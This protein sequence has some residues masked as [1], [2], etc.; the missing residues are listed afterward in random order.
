MRL[1]LAGT[2]NSG[3]GT[4]LSQALSGQASTATAASAAANLGYI[5]TP[6]FNANRLIILDIYAVAQANPTNIITTM[7]VVGKSVGMAG[8]QHTVT[9]AYDGITFFG[10]AGTITGT[11]RV[12]GYKNS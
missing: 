1:R 7:A 4:Y 6:A 11:V 5:D 8:V 9:T 3:A 10:G 2:D 12:Y